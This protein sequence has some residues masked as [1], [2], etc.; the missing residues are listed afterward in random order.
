MR[1]KN[2]N[3]CSFTRFLFLNA[4]AWLLFFLSAIIIFFPLSRIA[5]WIFYIQLAAGMIPLYPACRILGSWNDKKREY[6]VLFLR[7][8]TDFRPDT[9]KPY[10]DAPCGR[11][12]VRLVLHDLGKSHE[13]ENILRQSVFYGEKCFERKTVVTFHVDKKIS[14]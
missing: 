11:L 2:S 13:Y 14:E 7:N 12:L 9:F 4:Y 5:S 1:T 3:I 8:R 10:I 6:S